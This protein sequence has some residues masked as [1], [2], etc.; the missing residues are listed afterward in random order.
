MRRRPEQSSSTRHKHGSRTH[1]PSPFFPR[2]LPSFRPAA[3]AWTGL[4]CRK[5]GCSALRTTTSHWYGTRKG[6]SVAVQACSPQSAWR[7]T[8]MSWKTAPGTLI[9]KIF[10]S[11]S[12]TTDASCCAC[13]KGDSDGVFRFCWLAVGDDRLFG[14]FILLGFFHPQMGHPPTHPRSNEGERACRKCE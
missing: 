4:P 5:D 12:E 10:A 6:V 14:L 9:T 11:L 13:L 1:D 3:T 8:P 7:V 2:F